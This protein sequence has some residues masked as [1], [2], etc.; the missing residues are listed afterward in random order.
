MIASSIFIISEIFSL[1]IKIIMHFKLK[2]ENIV[3]DLTRT[4][5]IIGWVS[6]TI[7]ISWFYLYDKI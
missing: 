6:L 1:I 4:D 3:F 7:I 5:K 2:M